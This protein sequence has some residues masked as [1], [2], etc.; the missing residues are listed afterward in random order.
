MLIVR[1][2]K[3]IVGFLSQTDPNMSHE[4]LVSNGNLKIGKDTNIS[5]ALISIFQP[6]TNN[7]NIEIGSDCI[8][9]GKLVLLNT[10]TKVKIGNRVFIGPDTTL[11]CYESIEIQDD[12]MISWGC[13]LI[14]TNAHA[15]SSENRKNDVLDWAKG[16]QYK[17][18]DL[19]ESK[20]ICVEKKS[21]IGFN[22]I[23]TKGVRISEGTIVASG[24]V[25]TK[26]T[27][28]FDIVG[29]NPAQFIKKTD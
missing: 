22:S 17:N 23:V 9:S 25:A 2:L 1:V 4:I 7:L 21:W 3:K 14:D 6:Q 16:P 11:F 19:V 15:L 5:S 8:I 28:P 29:G 27:N 10:N 12:V 13:T 26:S 20:P 18:W 24:S